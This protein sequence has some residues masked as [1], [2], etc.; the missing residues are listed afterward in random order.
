MITISRLS[1]KHGLAR[2]TLLYYDRI[3]LLKPEFRDANGYRYY[4]KADDEK[5]SKICLYR[6]IGI[7]LREI[8]QILNSSM[9]RLTAAL[10][11]RMKALNSEIADLR[12]QQIQIIRMLKN[13]KLQSVGEG[14]T[15]D[16][17]ISFLKSSGFTD[18]DLGRWHAQFESHSPDNHQ[19]FLQ[20]LGIPEEEIE[21]LRR[22][23]GGYM[24]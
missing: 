5:L 17:W 7:P 18:E 23:A 12:E 1:K 13:K 3:E 2:S 21:V 16:T 4:S 11:A 22:E 24:K 10:E 9:N 20:F 6:R 19:Q 15:K 8:K 14:L